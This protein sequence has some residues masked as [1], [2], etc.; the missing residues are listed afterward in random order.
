MITVTL[1]GTD[2]PASNNSQDI[3]ETLKTAV[4]LAKVSTGDATILPPAEALHMVTTATA[5]PAQSAGSE[6]MADEHCR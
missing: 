4:L 6:L 3:L 2:G 5:R 1:I